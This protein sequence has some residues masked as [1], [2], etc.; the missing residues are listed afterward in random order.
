MNIEALCERVTRFGFTLLETDFAIDAKPHKIINLSRTEKSLIWI[1]EKDSSFMISNPSKVGDYISIVEKRDYSYLMND[2]GAIQI[3]FVYNKNRISR[4]RLLYYPCPF[5]IDPHEMEGSD[6]GSFPLIDFINDTFMDNSEDNLLLR[7]P[8]RFDYVPTEAAD[9]HP[10]SHLTINDP[11]CR[12][13][14]RSPLEF[15][16]FVKFILENFYMEAWQHGKIKQDLIFHQEEECLSVHDKSRV[17]LNW[18]YST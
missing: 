15:D 14:V 8:F 2:G 9:F 4:H 1:R 16:T 18:Q 12:I 5:L 6:G 10:A 13:P 17:F 7:S 3:A 11:S